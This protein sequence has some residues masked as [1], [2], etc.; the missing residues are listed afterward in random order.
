ML[1][2]PSLGQLAPLNTVGA[3]WDIFCAVIDNY[4]DIG[5]CWRLA[6]QLSAEFGLRVRLWV[7][8]LAPLQRLCPAVQP[9]LDEQMA[10]AVAIR[11]WR[12]QSPPSDAA[13]V[14]IEAFGCTLPTQYLTAMVER[15][16]PSLWI[17]LEY[18][19]AEPWV[20]GCHGLSSPQVQWKLNKYFFFPGFDAA[21]GGLLRE[22]TLLAERRAFQADAAQPA[23]FFATLGLTIP[24]GATV[25]SVFTYENP[26]L[27]PW[28]DALA[29]ADQAVWCLIP[30]GRVV[31]QVEA[32]FGGG[33]CAVGSVHR[34]GALTV[35]ILPFLTQ[36]DYDRLLWSC[37]ANWVRGEDSFVR[38]QWAGRPFVWQIYPQQER[39]HEVKLQAFLDLYTKALAPPAASVLTHLWWAFNGRGEVEFAWS[40]WQRQLPLLIE[41]AGDWSSQL[42]GVENLAAR[43]VQFCAN[44]V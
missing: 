43:L 4:G 42:A 15:A 39:A 41:H 3:R 21:S 11:R 1:Q 19:S 6:R 14:V 35:V 9:G 36:P 10:G 34:R 18:L 44:R 32:Y 38:A 28:F 26:A 8:D 31:A 2:D 27:E 29:S 33:L 24:L 17:N 23:T 22:R 12:A 16:S 5:V 25:Y 7:D 13:D 40:Q 20:A 37:T 30:E